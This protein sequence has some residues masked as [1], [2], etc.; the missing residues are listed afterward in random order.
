MAFGLL[1]DKFHSNPKIIEVGNA[2]AGLYARALSYCADQTT[3]GFIPTGWAREIGTAGLCKK[4]CDA[5]LWLSVKPGDGP[6]VYVREDSSYT[7]HIVK[8]GYFILDYLWH[9]DNR[10]QVEK[11]RSELHEKRS[12]SGKLGAIAR[13]Q[14]DSKPDGKGDG[15]AIASAWQTDGPTPLPLERASRALPVARSEDQKPP[16]RVSDQITRSLKEAS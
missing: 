5:A 8:P 7:V 11:R 12:K 3:D 10:E 6:F 15:K 1:D 16:D 14:L 9:N 4:L 13:W 2:G